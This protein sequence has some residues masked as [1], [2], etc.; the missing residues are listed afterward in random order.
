MDKPRI[1]IVDDE[2]VVRSLL[3]RALESDGYEIETMSDGAAAGERVK[4]GNYNLLIT[5]LKMPGI[6]GADLLGILKRNNPFVEAIVMTGY[7]T[8]ESAVEA[9]QMGAYDFICKPF[10]IHDIAMKIRRCLERQRLNASFVKLSELDSLCALTRVQEGQ[11]EG[12]SAR[13]LRAALDA[14]G[15]ETAGLFRCRNG[16]A[17]MSGFIG[18][19]V[20]DEAS[21]ASCESAVSSLAGLTSPVFSAA[22]DASVNEIDGAQSRALTWLFPPS[23]AV[24]PIRSHQGVLGALC[25][26]GKRHAE[27]T[28]REK[29]LL[30]VIAGQAAVVMENEELYRRLRSQVEQLEHTVSELRVTQDRLI[31]SEKMASVGNLAS[32]IAHEIRNPLGI[33]LAGVECI[34]SM[35]QRGDQFTMAVEKIR[36]SVSRANKIIVDLLKFSRSAAVEFAAVDLRQA[37]EEARVLFDERARASGVRIETV[38]PPDECVVNGD[39]TL[40]RQVFFNLLTNA[41]D[42]TAPGG[43]VSFRISRECLGDGDGQL[44]VE[45]ADTGCGIPP[46][47]LGRIFDPFYTTKDPGKGTGLGLSITHMIIDRHHGAIRAE[48]EPGKGCRFIITLP[49]LAAVAQAA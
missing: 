35:D 25:V 33:I 1:L 22:A 14:C 4:S 26:G 13:L 30:S 23:L 7:P 40:L 43:A 42:A 48:S 37:V 24:L 15:A 16:R 44:M 45:V 11:P 31:Q 19:G 17:V 8:V 36:A 3:V 32:G 38:F 5:D 41:L 2:E 9:L 47:K 28:S 29:S 12:Y 18:P 49:A 46:E 21:V 10:D 39:I 27:F 20:T 34:T 6:S